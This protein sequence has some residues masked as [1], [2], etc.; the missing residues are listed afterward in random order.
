M[1]EAL[2]RIRET[3]DSA[4]WLDQPDAM[5]PYLREWRGAFEGRAAAVVRPADTDQVA[6][7]V[8][9]CHR[10]GIGV[11]PQSGNTGLCG[12]AAAT[13]EA[14]IVLS[15]DRMRR[16]RAVDPENFTI[17]ADAG[18]VLAELH[19][20]ARKVDRMFP[21]SLAAEGSCRIGGN[22][23]TNAGGN[24]VLR[25]GTARDLVL[26]LEVVL[27]DGRVW[28]GL[29]EL[30]KDNTGYDLKQ[31]FIGAE[32]TLGVITAAVLK[33]FPALRERRTALVAVPG[34]RQAITLLARLRSGSGEAVS[35]C[36][37]IGRTALTLAA[38]HLPQCSDPFDREH[39]WYLL[40]ELTTAR[41]Q[42]G[43]REVL[44]SVL[45][46]ALEEGLVQDAVIAESEAQADSLWAIRDG[47]PEA[48]TREGASIKHDI[49]VPVSRVPELLETAGARVEAALPGVRVCAFGHIG[50]GN[51]HFNLSQ[52]QDGDGEAFLAERRGLNRI[53]HDVVADLGGS[54]SAEHGI[55]RLK[56]DD[57]RHY[58]DGV[59]LDLMRAIKHTLDPDGIMNPGAV[60][61]DP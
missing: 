10:S 16:I 51:I 48:Q 30:R 24:N 61:P 27:P 43:L 33:L 60:L 3:V 46:E 47:I 44:E 55:G 39:P 50:D 25:Y 5:A 7:V 49:S 15:L 34:S 57:M 2:T 4:G 26:G 6:A 18:C 59:T 56:L 11:V 58:R 14:W 8:A 36:E 54:F 32:G 45:S 35:A 1:T 17:I 13:D 52:P 22:L 21:L 41:P 37:L 38:R 20:A 40:V 31:L 28:N 29:S 12:G 42:A 53:V 23:A 19:E 9:E